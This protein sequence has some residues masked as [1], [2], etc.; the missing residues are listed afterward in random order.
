ML[1]LLANV[2]PSGRT[3]ILKLNSPA[4]LLAIEIVEITACVPAGTV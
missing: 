1:C 3:A 4:V 2:S